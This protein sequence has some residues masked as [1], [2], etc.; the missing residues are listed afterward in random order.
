MN[1][2][3]VDVPPGEDFHDAA[4]AA[5]WADGAGH[6]RPWRATIFEHFVS[7]VASAPIDHRRFLELGSGPG[8]LAKHRAR[9][10]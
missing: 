6:R 2:D 3:D 5:A 4:T 9:V 8:L 7:I 10:R 1:E